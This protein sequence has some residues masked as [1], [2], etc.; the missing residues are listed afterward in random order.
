MNI[1][2]QH[3]HGC[4]VKELFMSLWKSGFSVLFL[5]VV[6]VFMIADGFIETPEKSR[7]L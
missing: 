4:L 7:Q 3:F 1:F 6:V 2:V 5:L